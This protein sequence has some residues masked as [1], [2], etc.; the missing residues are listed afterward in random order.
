MGL[1]SVHG[2]LLW[3]H[4]CSRISSFGAL[5]VRHNVLLGVLG[6]PVFIVKPPRPGGLGKDSTG[7]GSRPRLSAWL[8]GWLSAQVI[9]G[10]ITSRVQPSRLAR[11]LIAGWEMPASR[12]ISRK[13]CAPLRYSCSIQAQSG[14]FGLPVRSG[15]GSF[16]VSLTF[17]FSFQS[18]AR[19]PAAL[20]PFR[21]QGQKCRPLF[22]PVL[23]IIGTGGGQAQLVS[24]PLVNYEW[25]MG[26]RVVIVYAFMGECVGRGFAYY[27]VHQ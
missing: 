18:S 23:S 17:R 9:T 3:A 12:A 6:P 2:R 1:V 4:S 8:S 14:S 11:L 13:D 5:P 15:N 10:V 27:L 21:F 7:Q 24:L 26:E 16:A 25:F 19:L 22:L 20:S